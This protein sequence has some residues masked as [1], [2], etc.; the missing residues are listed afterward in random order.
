M[1][2]E[3]RVARIADLQ[4][5]FDEQNEEFRDD[6]FPAE[7]QEQ[8]D[9]NQRELREHEETVAQLERRDAEIRRQAERQENRESG[10]SLP[11]GRP[12]SPQLISR[13]GEREVYDLST[14]R[15]N[16]LD[17]ARASVEMRDR[18]LRAVEI[19]HFAH[20]DA[21]NDHCRSHVTKLLRRGMEDDDIEIGPLARRIL[22]TGSPAYKRAFAKLVGSAMR[23]VP[24]FANLSVEEQ[25]AVDAVRAMSVGTGSS[26]GFAVPYTLDPTVVPTSNLS[27][28]PF[29]RICR[30]EQI[31]G[32][33]WN[34]VTS[35]GVTAGYATE[36]TEASDNSP[37]LAQPTMNVVRA[38]C[39]VPVS[40][41]LTQDWGALQSELA[42]LIQDAKDDLEA[43]K[44]T[45]GTGTNEPTGLITGAT[46]TVTT[47]TAA[48]FAISDLYKLEEALGP[49]FRPRAQWLANRF[50]YNKARQFDTA[51][52]SGVWLPGLQPGLNNDV[53]RG[54]NTGFEL[55]GY[56]ANEDSAMAAALTTG[57]KIAVLGDPRYYLIVDRIGM[58][59]EV[60]P[61][62][63]GATSRFPT[64]QRGFYAFWRNNANVLSANA[65]RVL[66]T[67]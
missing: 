8:W 10:A 5:W 53:P 46:T 60:I 66:V 32:L 44:F 45:T 31:T 57:T 3:E 54:G 17:P 39:F 50:I 67:L 33:Q 62:L 38:Q 37:T 20:P 58:D 49:R 65:F 13:M 43:T 59:I 11:Q 24:G 35:A 30:T 56:P 15:Y 34:G 52:G 2:R 55:I 27:V 48:T 14:V 4:R 23:G 26:G 29:R 61:H 12:A 36:G 16:P 63:F 47:A 7:V 25:R 51:G 28:N 6:A 18:A 21:D 22:T 64:G 1:T 9:A 19:A 42:S 41:E 40:I